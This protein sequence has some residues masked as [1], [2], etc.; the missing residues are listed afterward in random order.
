MAM[1]P[2]IA[3]MYLKG[4]VKKADRTYYETLTYADALAGKKA[5][6]ERI[7][8]AGLRGIAGINFDPGYPVKSD[9]SLIPPDDA[10]VIESVTKQLFW[11]IPNRQFRVVTP[12]TKGFSGFTNGKKVVCGNTVFELKN[13]FAAVILT[14]RDNAALESSVRILMT[15]VARC[16]NTGTKYNALKTRFLESGKAPILLQPV[17][18]TVHLPS[19]RKLSVYALDLAGKRKKKIDASFDGKILSIPIGNAIHYEL[20]AE[21]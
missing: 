11:D 4:D 18:G 2:A 20:T 19:V 13:D 1:W 3:A 15:A 8:R 9:S 5:N 16:W 7:A 6:S 17:E 21:P 14:S 12:G 10:E